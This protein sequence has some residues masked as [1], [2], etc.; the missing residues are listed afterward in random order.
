MARTPIT[1]GRN[2]IGTARAAASGLAARGKLLKT[3]QLTQYGGYAD[4]GFYEVGI[5]KAYTVL[6]TGQFSGTTAIVLNGKTDTH[7]N[8][9]VLDQNTG[10]MWSRY[11]AAS[12]G[13]ASDGKLPWTTNGSGE[14]IF[15][16]VAACNAAS[17]GGYTDWR[18]PNDLELKCL[19]DMEQP[20]AAPDAAAFP[21]WPTSD[22]V[23][24][25]VSK[26]ND[27][28]EAMMVIFSSGVVA[29]TI[30]SV[31]YFASVVRGG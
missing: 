5:A 16:Y 9:C 27:T 2:P 22:W 13:P 15:A 12:V 31:A 14:G 25:S 1:A 6:T 28:T 11:A 24:S 17:L 21:S 26:P 8:N 7:S 10:L 29:N 19:C 30:K 3:G 20:T 18:I 23:W 4:D